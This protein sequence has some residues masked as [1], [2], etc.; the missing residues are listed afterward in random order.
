[1]WSNL[2][3]AL[4][5]IYRK[6]RSPQEKEAIDAIVQRVTM[7]E[8]IRGC[9]EIACLRLKLKQHM[10]S[11]DHAGGAE[12]VWCCCVVLEQVVSAVE[13]QEVEAS[14]LEQRRLCS[15]AQQNTK[16]RMEEV[17]SCPAPLLCVSLVCKASPTD[18][19][20]ADTEVG[21]CFGGR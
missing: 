16:M 5:T 8:L 7:D 1:M 20:S 13:M 10:A 21:S 14:E 15:E 2:V 3:C 19:T 9:R 11:V 4:T 17:F 6:K 18:S 12:V